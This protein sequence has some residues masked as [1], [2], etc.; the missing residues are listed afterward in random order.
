MS[1]ILHFNGFTKCWIPPDKILK[2]ALDEG[3]QEVIVIGYTKKD[4]F[5]FAASN[6]DAADNLWLL[7]SMEKT[8]LEVAP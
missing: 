5:Y 4:E 7:K 1:N 8:L 2:D 3:M 6:P